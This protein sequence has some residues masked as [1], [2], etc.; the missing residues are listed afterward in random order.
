[1]IYTNI[2]KYYKSICN[3]V[4]MEVLKIVLMKI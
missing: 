2:I 4:R 1:M 3:N